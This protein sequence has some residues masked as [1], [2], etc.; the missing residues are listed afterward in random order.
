M[1]PNFTIPILLKAE[2]ES[3]RKTTSNGMLTKKID[4][5]F[6]EKG[7]PK[8]PEVFGNFFSMALHEVKNCFGTPLRVISKV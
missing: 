7:K 3:A 1:F 5:C 6:L 4:V 2:L 8:V